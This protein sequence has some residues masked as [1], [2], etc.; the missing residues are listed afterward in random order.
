MRPPDEWDDPGGVVWKAEK[1]IYG[2]KDAARCWLIR[3]RMF[4]EEL[5]VE[6]FRGSESCFISRDEGGQIIG[7]I[8]TH[9]DDILFTGTETFQS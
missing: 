8:V 4:F 3:F 1:E 6:C 2:L 5:K 9:V 7:F